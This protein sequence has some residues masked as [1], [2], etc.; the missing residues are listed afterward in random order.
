MDSECRLQNKLSHIPET[1]VIELVKKTVIVLGN[2]NSCKS[3]REHTRL[4][5]SPL[6]T[7]IAADWI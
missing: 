7:L 2:Q 3:D 6:Y 5:A 4:L 1:A